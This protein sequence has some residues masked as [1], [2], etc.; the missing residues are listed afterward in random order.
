MHPIHYSLIINV[1]AMAIAAALAWKFET[2]WILVIVLMLSQHEMA[3]FQ[4]QQRQNDLDDMD[5]GEPAMGFLAD[6][7]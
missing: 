3:R 6:M 4:E 1:L 5:D 7:K 2:P